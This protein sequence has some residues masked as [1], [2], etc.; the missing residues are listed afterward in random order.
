MAL[1]SY[2]NLKSEVLDM[3]HRPDLAG[4][5]DTAID[6]CEAQMN[7]EFRT[8]AQESRAIATVNS[9][10]TTLP[11]DF[12]ELRNVQLNTSPPKLLRYLSPEAMDALA[13][14]T[15]EP[16]YYTFVG[17]ELQFSP[18]PDGDYTVEIVYF[19]KID[20]LSDANPSN[21]VLV[22]WPE[23]YLYGSLA[24]L[25][26]FVFDEQRAA[27]WQAVFA[28]GVERVKKQDKRARYS[29]NALAVSVL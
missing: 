29:G 23:L 20:G 8:L 16:I 26:M 15:G 19:A 21:F 17:N 4:R 6:L 25:A 11:D 12:L 18:N 24:H 2:T 27:A 22:N 9:E 13:D 14:T 10:Y 7:R 5:V 28:M 3:M 1:D